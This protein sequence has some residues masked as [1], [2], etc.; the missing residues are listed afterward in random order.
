[1][2]W[3]TDAESGAYVPGPAPEPKAQPA[4]AETLERLTAYVAHV[5]RE[6]R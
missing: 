2:Q 3:T 6:V 4:L 5:E 1:M